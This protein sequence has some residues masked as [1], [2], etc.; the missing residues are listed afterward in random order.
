MLDI[1]RPI[2]HQSLITFFYTPCIAK[3]SE[4]SFSFV[5]E[6]TCIIRKLIKNYIRHY[7]GC[8]GFH[9]HNNK[10]NHNNVLYTVFFCELSDD[11]S[12]LFSRRI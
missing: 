11:G 3:I 8:L 7:Y 6:I 2:A 12:Y 10:G 4:I 9:N 5:E 1:K